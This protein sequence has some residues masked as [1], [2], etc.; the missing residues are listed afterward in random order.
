MDART[1]Y[2]IAPAFYNEILLPAIEA[3]RLT[4]VSD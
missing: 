2:A 3:A 1:H 4:L